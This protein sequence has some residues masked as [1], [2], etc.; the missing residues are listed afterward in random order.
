MAGV[1]NSNGENNINIIWQR[2]NNGEN[3]GCQY[4]NESNVKEA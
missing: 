4:E 1:F 2:N 3:G